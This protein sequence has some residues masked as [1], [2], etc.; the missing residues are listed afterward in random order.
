MVH[1]VQVPDPYLAPNIQKSQGPNFRRFGSLI[2]K[3]TKFHQATGG[4][5]PRLL[6]QFLA[7]QQ[8]QTRMTKMRKIQNHQI[9]TTHSPLYSAKDV[10]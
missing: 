1:H 5:I 3:T 7:I 4:G 8:I 2:Q 9:Q 10:L 6:I